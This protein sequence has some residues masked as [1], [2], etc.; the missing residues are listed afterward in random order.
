M[1]GIMSAKD[2]RMKMTTDT[3]NAIK[4]IKFHAWE[5]DFQG[6]IQAERQK[7]YRALR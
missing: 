7:E 4:I 6:K 2:S 1:T 5:S 3:L